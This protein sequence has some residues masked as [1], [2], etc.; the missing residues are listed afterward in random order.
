MFVCRAIR[1]YVSTDMKF[2]RESEIGIQQTDGR[3]HT[4]IETAGDI[5]D[6]DLAQLQSSLEA[7][8]DRFTNLG[9]GWCLAEIIRFTLH[10][11]QFRPMAG[12]N[13]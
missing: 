5:S 13:V 4:N 8:L 6:V 3:F 12:S 1:W 10:I 7:Q 2:F 9:S 11:S